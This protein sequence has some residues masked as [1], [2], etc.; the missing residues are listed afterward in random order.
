MS[1]GRRAVVRV[2][3]EAPIVL[4]RHVCAPD[5]TRALAEVAA[6]RHHL[7][8]GARAV[9]LLVD[10]A[11]PPPSFSALRHYRDL[12]ASTTEIEWVALVTG[13]G[14]FGLTIAAAGMAQLIKLTRLAGHMGSFTELGP[15]CTWLASRLRVVVDLEAVSEG[16]EDLLALPPPRMASTG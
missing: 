9:M 5:S 6:M 4:L 12:A 10:E 13:D 15:A 3:Y 2:G 7:E 11:I 1:E 16:F 14:G 8:D